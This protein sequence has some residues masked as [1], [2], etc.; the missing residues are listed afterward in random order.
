VAQ[1]I[2]GVTAGTTAAPFHGGVPRLLS[3]IDVE[4]DIADATADP[5]NIPA[6]R[7][8]FEPLVNEY[9]TEVAADGALSVGYAGKGYRAAIAQWPA[10]DRIANSPDESGST[11]IGGEVGATIGEIPIASERPDAPSVDNASDLSARLDHWHDT[12]QYV[13]DQRP[14]TVS[15]VVR[16]AGSD[17]IV[18]GPLILAKAKTSGIDQINDGGF[19]IAMNDFIAQLR[20]KVQTVRLA[21]TGGVEGGPELRGVRPQII[22]GSPPNVSGLLVASQPY[23]TYLLH[24]DRAG[25]PL[26][27]VTAGYI[28]ENPLAPSQYVV[29]LGE[30]NTVQVITG[31]DDTKL[32]TWDVV[33]PAQT[34]AVLVDNMR[35]LLTTLGRMAASELDDKLLSI[36]AGLVPFSTGWVIGGE[37]QFD[38]TLDAWLKPWGW[39]GPGLEGLLGAGVLSDP[40]FAFTDYSLPEHAIRSVTP[41]RPIV[42]RSALA[43]GYF[44]N[45][46][47]VDESGIAA[48]ALGTER[49]QWAQQPHYRV[50][51]NRGADD[52][53]AMLY[54][55]SDQPDD[56]VTPF[57]V[58]SEARVI[59]RWIAALS[60]RRWRPY[61]VIADVRAARFQPNRVVSFSW[62]RWNETALE[63]PYWIQSVKLLPNEKSA[64]V[65][66]NVWRLPDVRVLGTEVEGA[67]LPDENGDP[68]RIR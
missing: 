54:P 39:W 30:S 62:P 65:E 42:P 52:S 50:T 66:L 60:S 35:Y 21:G 33:G 32:P 58:E 61:T 1:T 3:T 48:V 51:E 68:M 47:Q 24:R 41:L 59:Y 31:L 40:D 2:T 5:A 29:S 46:T 55:S 12:D 38:A 11:E 10:I 64:D 17:L 44:K 14:V 23:P 7:V 26:Q 45:W 15:V 57:L 9:S 8:V 37:D 4:R 67:W 63:L 25:N 56:Y 6:L 28:G 13:W 49:G 22:V 20:Q 16:R 19:S 36:L 18:S 53:L 34:G 27:G 43:V